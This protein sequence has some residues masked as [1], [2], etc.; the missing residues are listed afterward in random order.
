MLIIDESSKLHKK[1]SLV[2]FFNIVCNLKFMTDI[3]NFHA[4]WGSES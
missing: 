4:E 2:N 3:A 1:G